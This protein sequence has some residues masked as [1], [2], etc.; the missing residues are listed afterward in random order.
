MSSRI[1]ALSSGVLIFKEDLVQLFWARMRIAAP[2][3]FV[4]VSAKVL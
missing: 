1:V 2:F 4:T 3:P